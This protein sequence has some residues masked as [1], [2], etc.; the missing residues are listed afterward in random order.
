M[1][2]GMSTAIDV[3]SLEPKSKLEGRE[4]VRV[5]DFNSTED[6]SFGVHTWSSKPLACAAALALSI[7]VTPHVDAP[8]GYRMVST[9]ATSAEVIRFKRPESDDEKSPMGYGDNA[10]VSDVPHIT[11]TL[12]ANADSGSQMEDSMSTFNH[13]WQ[14][15]ERQLRLAINA[16]CYLFI[17]V[18]I[19]FLIGG[20]GAGWFF[21]LIPGAIS[22]F[23]VVGSC[24]IQLNKINE[25]RDLVVSTG[26]ANINQ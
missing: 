11:T 4:V 15:K 5:L 9:F 18:L 7:G 26:R 24:A 3:Y 14:P 23:G 8:R 21:A 25:M 17:L 20:V 1:S 6:S 22:A 2:L 10:A 13:E 19:A 16:T 12:E